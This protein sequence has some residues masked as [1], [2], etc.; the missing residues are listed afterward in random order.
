GRMSATHAAIIFSLEPVFAT[1][2][3][4][5]MR[6]AGEWTG[7][8]ANLGA[9]LILAGIIVSELRWGE[10]RAAGRTET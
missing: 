2:F 8:R 5:W 9:A 3:A 6:G 7:G 1:I 10:R 4:V